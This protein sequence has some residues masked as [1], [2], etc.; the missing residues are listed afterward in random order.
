MMRIEINGRDAFWFNA[1]IVEWEHQY[2]QRALIKEASGFFIIENDWL[3]D[4]KRIAGACFSTVVVAPMD[5]SRR[6]LFRQFLPGE[7]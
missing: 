1:F 6:S 7:S 2:P 3:E 5:P 4:L